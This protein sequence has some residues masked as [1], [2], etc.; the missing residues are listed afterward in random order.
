MNGRRFLTGIFLSMLVNPVLADGPYITVDVT[1]TDFGNAESPAMLFGD[2][3][4][5]RIG[6]DRGFSFGAG[7]ALS[8]TAALEVRYANLGDV[9]RSG[10]FLTDFVIPGQG[11]Q[12]AEIPFDFEAERFDL[13]LMGGVK[14]NDRFKIQ[15]ILGFGQLAVDLKEHSGIFSYE[16]VSGPIYGL[17]VEMR[18]AKSLTIRLRG[19]RLNGNRNVDTAGLGLKYEF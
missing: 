2:V 12:M 16:D 4:N 11:R 9:S 18:I 17:G 6:S 5:S 8:E 7:Y 3:V 1:T 19:E 14:L 13:T 10:L 15:G